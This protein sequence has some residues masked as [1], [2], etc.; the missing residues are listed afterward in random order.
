[1]LR[2]L[3]I[4]LLFVSFKVDASLPSGCLE[5][6]RNAALQAHND[7]RLRHS[8]GYLNTDLNLD[9]SALNSATTMS[10]TNDFAHTP[11]LVNTGENIFASYT[12]KSPSVSQCARNLNSLFFDYD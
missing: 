11:D 8:A 2:F 9:D 6:F 5:A 10:I 4:V 1:M 12:T 7:Y 3:I